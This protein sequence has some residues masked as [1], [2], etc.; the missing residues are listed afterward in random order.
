MAYAYFGEG[1]EIRASLATTGK[2]ITSGKSIEHTPLLQ[3]EDYQVTTLQPQRATE[4]EAI[5]RLAKMHG[6]PVSCLPSRPFQAGLGSLSILPPEIRLQIWEMIIP[7]TNFCIELKPEQKHIPVTLFDP[8]PEQKRITEVSP[9]AKIIDN[10]GLLRASKQIHDEIDTHFFHN[11]SLAVIFTATRNS[12]TRRKNFEKARSSNAGLILEGIYSLGV[13]RFVN[14]D[15]FTSIKLFIEWPGPFARLSEDD[16]LFTSVYRFARELRSW[17]SAGPYAF[18]CP[19]LEVVVTTRISL[20]VNE[21]FVK[22]EQD[23]SNLAFLLNPLR[24]LHAKNSTVEADCVFRYGQEWLPELLSQVTEDMQKGKCSYD[25]Q[26]RQKNMALALSQCA[27]LTRETRGQTNGGPLP[28]GLPEALTDDNTEYVPGYL[29][30]LYQHADYQFFLDTGELPYRPPGRPVKLE[31]CGRF[32]RF[33][34]LDPMPP[35]TSFHEV[36][37]SPESGEN[38]IQHQEAPNERLSKHPNT[39]SHEVALS[40]ESSETE[41][42]NQVTPNELSLNQ[43]DTSSHQA[44]TYPESSKKG[45][46][47]QEPQ[48]NLPQDQPT[49]SPPDRWEIN[50]KKHLPVNY[51][52]PADFAWLKQLQPITHAENPPG[53]YPWNKYPT[54]P[55]PTAKAK[56]Q[57]QKAATENNPAPQLD[58]ATKEKEPVPTSCKLTDSELHHQISAP[59]SA[60]GFFVNADWR[61]LGI[62]YSLTKRITLTRLSSPYP[63]ALEKW[64][65]RFL[66]EV[67]VKTVDTNTETSHEPN[68]PLMATAHD[69]HLEVVPQQNNLGSLIVDFWLL[70]PAIL[71]WYYM[72]LPGLLLSW[73]IANLLPENFELTLQGS[74]TTLIFFLPLWIVLVRCIIKVLAKVFSSFG[75]TGC[76][77]LSAVV[78]HCC[79]IDI[80]G[81]L[82]RLISNLVRHMVFGNC[83]TTYQL[84]ITLLALSAPLW[85]VVGQALRNE[86]TYTIRPIWIAL[87]DATLGL[88]KFRRRPDQKLQPGLGRLSTLPPEIR[89]EIWQ[90]LFVKS[91]PESRPCIYEPLQRYIRESAE[92]RK[93]NIS[94]MLQADKQSIF[95][96][97][98]SLDSLAIL[99]TSKQLHAEVRGDLYRSRT[100]RF[101]FDNNE[102]GLLL[103]RIGGRPTDYYIRLGGFC[104]ARDFGNTDFSMFKSLH[105]DIELP[106]NVCSSDKMKDLHTHLEEF[107]ELI[108]VWQ[109]RKYGKTQPKCP[110]IDIDIR[111]HKGTQLY[112]FERSKEPWWEISLLHIA[113]LLQP[114]RDIKNVEDVTIKVHFVLRYG[115]EWLPQVLREAIH[116]MKCVYLHAGTDQ[117]R[118]YS[119]IVQACELT[120][121]TCGSEIGGPLSEK[122]P[123]KPLA[124]E[125]YVDPYLTNPG[126]GEESRNGFIRYVFDLVVH[127][128]LGVYR[129]TRLVIALFLIFLITTRPT[130]CLNFINSIIPIG[131]FSFL[132]F[133]NYALLPA[134]FNY[135]NEVPSTNELWQDL[136]GIAIIW[137]LLIDLLATGP[138]EFFTFGC[139][140]L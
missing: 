63:R 17:E 93:Q 134:W 129:L 56:S 70:L 88:V 138:T 21:A 132:F 2:N 98:K 41:I 9:K 57:F 91:S 29:T 108:K 43:P 40:Q 139:Y 95:L 100:L 13:S 60:A 36:A 44:T 55:T 120:R 131:E 76:L 130:A 65:V 69:Q 34:Q 48:E 71:S 26:W 6:G 135:E 107:S 32:S 117:I 96:P 19:K 27:L 109:L 5:P 31:E 66:D 54:F 33:P 37:P 77:T 102:H 24:I 111:L 140:F 128:F 46:P 86:P 116:Q 49:P 64:T 137:S 59:P 73:L 127:I 53:I 78:L 123:E 62:L 74:V 20:D 68:T 45:L 28:I 115:H 79:G 80:P 8:M 1:F 42:Q 101:C 136:T 104:L 119:M 105:V 3:L 58:K 61:Y 103:Q 118:T 67:K 15:K 51:Q 99:R 82:L 35:D 30:V 81:I 114:L 22:M 75:L 124:G 11:R 83:Q 89:S 92:H 106:S 94:L 38:V 72:D 126:A 133:L 25:V 23:L 90:Y 10:L 4:V 7:T 12:I 113:T 39:A 18:S 52:P 112:D 121:D 87:S 125:T 47:H 14:F 16:S 97:T 110:P 84:S 122:P 50:P 85:V